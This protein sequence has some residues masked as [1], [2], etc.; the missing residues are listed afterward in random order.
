VK[1]VVVAGTHSGCGKTTVSLGLMAALT[2][3]GL[4]VAPFKVG[5]D[6]IDPGHHRQA[7]G[8]AGRNLDGWM[9]SRT[10]NEAA[11]RRAAAGADVAVVEGVMGLFDG[12]DGK[13]ESGSTAEMAK[14]LGLPVLLVVDARSMARSAAALVQ[15]FERFDP[16]LRFAGVAFNRIGSERH[17][18][19]L[20][21]AL[22]G[23]VRMPC[24]GGFAR[25][26][27]VAVPER[28]LGLVTA[29]DHPLDAQRTGRLAALVEGGLDVGGLLAALPEVAPGPAEAAPPPAPASPPVRIGVARDRAFC[30]YYEENLELLARSG[31]ELVA[32]SPIADREPPPGLD[33]LYFGGGYPELSAA[34]LAGN[35]P[36]RAAVRAA[37]EAG[38]PVYAECGGF[39]YL[40]A[41]LVDLA[42]GRAPMAG[43]FPFAARMLPRLKALG[44]R[45]VRLVRDTLLGPAGSLLRG[46]EFHYSELEPHPGPVDSAYAAAAR[47]DSRPAVPGF[48]AR[49]TLASY[50]HLHFGSAP[51]AAA[52]FVDACRG[53]RRE[54][55]PHE[56]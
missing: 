7:A 19:Y 23:S 52:A 48:L 56:A 6:F 18:A 44:Y 8:R 31:A 36:M 12:V 32:F 37:S 29:E 53:Y 10:A 17:L 27:A 54:R 15:G 2:R 47:G 5:P 42:G 16:G 51:A 21:E 13:S 49:R 43:C 1:G 46:H 28:H 38:M 11:F 9:L 20:R 14:W 40:C 4:R 24:L 45:E 26:E 33:G 50:V 30:F 41:E 35:A 34:A 55:T 39:M 3:R 22:A 25:D